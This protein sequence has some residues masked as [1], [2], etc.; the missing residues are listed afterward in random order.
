MDLRNLESAGS[1]IRARGVKGATGTQA[2]FLALFKGDHS[3]VE[4]L[5]E[6]VT[7]KAGF[8]SMFTISSQT[9]SRTGR[10]FCLQVL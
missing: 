2:T 4:E 1:N 6:L 7:K 8:E 3:K 5:D 10:P 9:Y